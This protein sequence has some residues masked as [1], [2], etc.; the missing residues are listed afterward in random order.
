MAETKGELRQPLT[1]MQCSILTNH[2]HV[3]DI[4]MPQT[5]ISSLYVT[6]IPD[7]FTL[8]I[9]YWQS[10]LDALLYPIT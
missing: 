4:V 1:G 7:V 5:E 3:T 10:L 2:I 6:I 8:T 9:E